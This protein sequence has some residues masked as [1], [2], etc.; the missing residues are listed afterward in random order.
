MNN[1]DIEKFHNTISLVK[2]TE[3]EIQPMMIIN[4]GKREVA[5]FRI[6]PYKE[7]MKE[8]IYIGK[9]NGLR[10]EAAI[11]TS[12]AYKLTIDKIVKVLSI[13]S[14]IDKKELNKALNKALKKY[15]KMCKYE[16]PSDIVSIKDLHKELKSINRRIEMCKFNNE[17]YSRLQV[18]R[19][20][21]VEELGFATDIKRYNNKFDGYRVAP[22]KGYIK[23]YGIN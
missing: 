14:D 20:E 13:N 4:K 6:I 8:I 17:D 18:R 11:L 16:Q 5:A 10:F 2:I 15:N 3:D 21:I 22:N 7:S 23:I 19:D 9:K 1:I 12:K